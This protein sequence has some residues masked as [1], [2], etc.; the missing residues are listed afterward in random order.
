MTAPVPSST[1]V[2]PATSQALTF[3]PALNLPTRMV[4]SRRVLLRSH[5]QS[6]GVNRLSRRT[7]SR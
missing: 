1:P 6:A 3:W 5:R 2:E 7:S 4:P